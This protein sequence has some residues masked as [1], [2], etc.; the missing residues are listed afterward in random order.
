M[1]RIKII[2]ILLFLLVAIISTLKLPTVISHPRIRCTWKYSID[3]RNYNTS[4]RFNLDKFFFE[5]ATPKFPIILEGF[6]DSDVINL[7]RSSS[8]SRRPDQCKAHV[9][10]AN[11]PYFPFVSGE[12]TAKTLVYVMPASFRIPDVVIN[13]LWRFLIDNI[14]DIFVFHVNYDDKNNVKMPNR[15]RAFQQRP[16]YVLE[17][18]PLQGIWIML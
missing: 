17:Y 3:G 8:I 2:I 18:D 14:R 9:V 13:H 16:T 7:N 4:I 12:D 15:L 10:I 1:L 11:S 6:L 5:S